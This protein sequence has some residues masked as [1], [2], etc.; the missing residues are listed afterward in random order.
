MMPNS[1]PEGRNFHFALNKHN[2][3][4]FLHTVPSTIAFKVQCA[5]FC[6]YNAEISTFSVKKCSVR[7]LPTTLT[8]KHLAE[9]DVKN[10]HNDV[11]KTL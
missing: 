3:F 5:L 2:G 7:L 9:N 1:Y 4:F 6:Q 11:K 8:S 10:G